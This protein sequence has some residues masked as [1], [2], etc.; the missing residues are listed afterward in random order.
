M[1]IGE[2]NV[3][4]RQPASLKNLKPWNVAVID[5]DANLIRPG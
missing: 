5:Q 1:L 2:K 4:G 3:V